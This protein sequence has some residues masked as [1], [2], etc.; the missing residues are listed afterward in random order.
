MADYV[1]LLTR[2]V[3]NFSDGGT[4]ATRKAIYDRARNVLLEQLRSLLPPLPESDITREERQLD[5]AITEV[6][7]RFT[8]QQA[9]PLPGLAV[10]AAAARN[11]SAPAKA[12]V[13]PQPQN[14]ATPSALPVSGGIFICYRRADTAAWADRIH[15]RL[16]H[17]FGREQVFIDVDDIE[18]GLDFAQYCPIELASATLLSRSLA[19]TG[20]PF[21]KG[22]FAD[23]SITRSI[24]YALKSKLRLRGTFALSQFSLTA[25]ACQDK[26]PCLTG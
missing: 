3:S 4:P 8:P 9:A 18:P 6:E 1:G 7:R 11:P 16:T 22:I 25:Q 17:R 23:V 21:V 19:R 5:A 24:T 13:A 20:S 2:A 10:R 14:R 26:K 15:D 12:A